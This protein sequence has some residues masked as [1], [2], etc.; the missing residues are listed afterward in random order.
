MN[1]RECVLH[2]VGLPYFEFLH[3]EIGSAG[4]SITRSNLPAWKIDLR[5]KLNEAL[6]YP[7]MKLFALDSEKI[8]TT[9]HHAEFRVHFVVKVRVMSAVVFCEELAGKSI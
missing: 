9:L 3:R 1:H 5:S 2:K 4:S 7:D 8:I 6:F